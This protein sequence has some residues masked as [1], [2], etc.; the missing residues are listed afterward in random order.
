MDYVVSEI[1]SPQFKKRRPTRPIRTGAIEPGYPAS[2]TLS[3]LDEFAARL[4][5]WLSAEFVKSRKQR[6][7]LKQM[8]LDLEELAY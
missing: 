7:T 5:A 2:H 6:R 3:S 1:F 4:S 8:L